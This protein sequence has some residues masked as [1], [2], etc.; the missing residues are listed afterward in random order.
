MTQSLLH[1][2]HSWYIGLWAWKMAYALFLGARNDFGRTQ[3]LYMRSSCCEKHSNKEFAFP[4]QCN[5]ISSCHGLSRTPF[6][7]SFQSSHSLLWPQELCLFD[8]F[9]MRS[10]FRIFPRGHIGKNMS[11]FHSECCTHWLRCHLVI[12]FLI[13]ERSHAKHI[14]NVIP[15]L[16]KVVSDMCQIQE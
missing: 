5:S 12:I 4:N 9:K 6:Q 8:S 10:E 3:R 15:S 16:V 11:C 14:F 2:C 1:L 13:I 7:N